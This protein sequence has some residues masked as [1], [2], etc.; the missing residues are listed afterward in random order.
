VVIG[1]LLVLQFN[2]WNQEKEN[3]KKEKWY[4]NNIVENLEYQKTILKEMILYWKESISIEKSLIK[5]FSLNYS[6]SYISSLHDKF[7]NVKIIYYYLF[8]EANDNDLNSIF[9]KKKYHVLNT[10][11]QVNRCEKSSSSN[12]ASLDSIDKALTLF[13]QNKLK[14][15]AFK[16][17]LINA[18]K[19]KLILLENFLDLVHKTLID[20]DS[21]IKKIDTYLGYTPDMVTN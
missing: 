20:I 4:L 15:P 2:A 7:L 18:V 17:E 12:E 10:Y 19:T 11:S 6:F 21:L 8:Y 1:I 16:L 13:T 14:E 5:D 9:Y 3:T